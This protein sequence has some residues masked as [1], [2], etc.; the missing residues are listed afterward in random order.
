MTKLSFDAAVREV[1]RL[2]EIARDQS[3]SIVERTDAYVR[4]VELIRDGKDELK[5]AYE[6]LNAATA[7]MRGE[8]T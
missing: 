8:T 5:V 3:R 6:R 7:I 2:G 4:A 1:E